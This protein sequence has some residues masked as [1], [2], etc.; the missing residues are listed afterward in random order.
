M[1]AI[2]RLWLISST[3]LQALFTMAAS[4]AIWKSGQPGVAVSRGDPA[5]T[6]LLLFVCVAFMSVSLGL[7]GIMGKRLN[8]PFST[9]SKYHNP[10]SWCFLKLTI[11]CLVV[12][13]TI[14]CANPTYFIYD[15]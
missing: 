2:S 6:N 4:I 5:W 7:Q 1:G 3:L 9:T 15:G 12:L 13:T 10:P 14:W 8:T 11:V